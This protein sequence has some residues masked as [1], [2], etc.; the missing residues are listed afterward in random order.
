LKF[1]R[2]CYGQ[3]NMQKLAGGR[4]GIRNTTA[5]IRAFSDRPPG[6]WLR[7]GLT[8]ICETLDPVVEKGYDCI[9]DRGL[10]HEPVLLQTRAPHHLQYLRRT[11]QQCDDVLFWIGEQIVDYWY[12]DQ[13][14]A[15]PTVS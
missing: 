10:A 1:I 13:R 11:L 2:Q 14:P 8:G 15:A 5:A 12:R 7:S 4:D 6:G 3:K 9:C